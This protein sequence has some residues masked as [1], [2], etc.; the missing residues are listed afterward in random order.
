MKRREKEKERK[1]VGEG[2][3]GSAAVCNAGPPPAR[4]TNICI[5]FRSGGASLPLADGH[6]P[7]TPSLLIGPAPTEVIGRGGGACELCS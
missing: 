2:R 5:Y 6:F 7:I 3:E 4:L 1:G